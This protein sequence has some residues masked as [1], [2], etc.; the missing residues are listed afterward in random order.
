MAHTV[1]YRLFSLLF[2]LRIPFARRLLNRKK[3][4][5][6]ELSVGAV[7]K[8]EGPYLE[9]WIKFHLALGVDHFYLVDD[10]ST[11][12]SCA[13]LESWVSEGKV[14]LL[15]SRRKNFN[16]RYAYRLILRLA[17]KQSKWLAF[18]DLDEFLFSPKYLNLKECL[19]N[20]ADLPAVFVY[21]VLYGASGHKTKPSGPVIENFTRCLPLELVDQ[22][23]FPHRAPEGYVTG[24]ARDGKSIVNPRAVWWP[25]AHYPKGIFWGS[26]LDENGDSPVTKDK[27][28]IRPPSANLLRINHYWSK[29]LEEM[30]K[31]ALRGNIST[32]ARGEYKFERLRQR[33]E[34]L[35][36]K[37]DRVAIDVLRRAISQ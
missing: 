11:D 28:V 24:W 34:G 5:V 2:P 18:I 20:F 37:V 22:D 33:E 30:E 8:N 4:F 36:R 26:V 32:E 12:N 16:Q 27:T 3:T 31:K 1:K 19:E 13:L 23:S 7:M 25:D 6:F 35:N 15:Q 21:W 10:H 29:S 17:R 14:T 9:E